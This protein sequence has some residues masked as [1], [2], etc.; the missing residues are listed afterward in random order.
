MEGQSK[1][2]RNILLGKLPIE[3]EEGIIFQDDESGREDGKSVSFHVEEYYGERD[4][5]LT[6]IRRFKI[7]NANKKPILSTRIENG[8]QRQ[9][10]PEQNYSSVKSKKIED[11]PEQNS[12]AQ[13]QKSED[14]RETKVDPFG[15][16]VIDSLSS[17][18][19]IGISQVRENS[20]ISNLV[21]QLKRSKWS[22]NS[23]GGRGYENMTNHDE[24][25]LEGQLSL[26]ENFISRFYWV[27]LKSKQFKGKLWL[28]V[29]M[30]GVII[31][32]IMI[33]LSNLKRDDENSVESNIEVPN[34]AGHNPLSRAEELLHVLESLSG[35]H[36]FDDVNSPEY[37]A[38][39]WLVNDYTILDAPTRSDKMF[40]R[41]IVS[42]LY[43]STSGGDWSKKY[44]F[45]S[46]ESVCKWNVAGQN[47]DQKYG[48]VCDDTGYV[49]GIDLG[50]SKQSQVCF[51]I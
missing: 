22:G 35:S 41:Y 29:F 34:N 51:M 13:S 32:L 39:E 2:L 21:T 48:V 20:K 12:N 37:M 24:D 42:L 4:E 45:L 36:T 16:S 27:R 18:E 23:K 30:V 1:L 9:D 38:Y 19:P 31:G 25:D 17:V 43:F 8:R 15:G 46:A 28:T 6:P 26:N 11:P 50:K 33:F 5:I 44:N 3:E 47:P 14:E 40:E 10:P 7:N 49:V